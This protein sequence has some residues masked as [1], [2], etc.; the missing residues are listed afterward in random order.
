MSWFCT[1]LLYNHVTRGKRELVA[2]LAVCSFERPF[3]GLSQLMRLCY[4]SHTQ[5]AKAQASLRILTVSPEP[6][7]FAHMKYG[8]RRSVRSKIRH[9]TPLWWPSLKQNV[10]RPSKVFTLPAACF[11]LVF[12]LLLLKYIPIYLKH[13]ETV[14]QSKIN[15][16]VEIRNILLLSQ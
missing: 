5:P 6:S 15:V 10:L 12:S 8:N 3:C 9:L 1:V 7:L 16:L 14:T 11:S 2:V 13:S 4:L